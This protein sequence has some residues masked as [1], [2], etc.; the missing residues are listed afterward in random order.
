MQPDFTACFALTVSIDGL[1][2]FAPASSSNRCHPGW[3]NVVRLA[4]YGVTKMIGI[5]R[6]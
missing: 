1:I 6:E 4:G 2:V 3:R 5:G